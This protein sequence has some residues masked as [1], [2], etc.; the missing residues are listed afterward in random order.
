VNSHRMAE[1]PSSQSPDKSGN[2]W[3][4]DADFDSDEP[5]SPADLTVGLANLGFIKAALRRGLRVCIVM[6]VVGLVCGVGYFAKRPPAYQAMTTVLLPPASYPEEILDDQLIA[7][8]RAVANEALV[9]LGIHEDPESLIRDSIIV[10]PTDRLLMITTKAASSDL[11]VKEA[12]ALADA[13][14][15]LQ[16]NLLG[17]QDKLVTESLNRQIAQDQQRV[18]TLDQ[19]IGQLSAQPH[20]ATQ[21]SQLT[22]LRAEQTQA[23]G[24][25]TALQQATQT[26]E[27]SMQASMT[28]TVTGSRV[29]DPAAPLASSRLKDRIAYALIGLIMGFAVGAGVVVVRAL[30]S[31]RLRRRDDVARLLGAPVKLSVGKVRERRLGGGESSGEIQRIA[32]HFWGLMSSRPHDI[33]SLAVVPADDPRVA[34]QSVVAL[35][36]GCAQRGLRVVL[37]DLSEGALAARLLDVN[38]PGVH[39]VRGRDGN[40]VVAIPEVSDIAPAGPLSGGPTSGWAGADN[41]SLAAACASA[42]ALVTFAAL[43]PSVGGDHLGGW[44]RTAAVVVTAGQSSAVRIRAVGEMIRL[45]GIERF[46]CVLIGADKS[47]ETLG[48]YTSGTDDVPQRREVLRPSPQERTTDEPYR[49]DEPYRS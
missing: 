38:T 43:D 12:N 15:A 21:Q 28:T 10:A 22:S 2:I 8:S 27:A 34:A 26:N 18:T 42:N 1:L 14:L 46:S 39:K 49:A 35:A 6:A 33:A 44:A 25:L 19:Q 47:D 3:V 24:A 17:A 32:M 41:Q 4:L 7:E 48:M 31:D 36:S 40:I 16:A 23:T 9:K 29:L 30:L 37:A 13:F 20:S 45:A 11:A 5:R